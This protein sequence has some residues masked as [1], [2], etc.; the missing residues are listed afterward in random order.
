[1]IKEDNYCQLLCYPFDTQIHLDLLLV[2]LPL[3]P[4]PSHIPPAGPTMILQDHDRVV[5]IGWS[6]QL[7]GLYNIVVT[8]F[9]RYRVLALTA[10]TPFLILLAA[11]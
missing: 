7:D 11:K 6:I 4:L 8:Y 2:L 10:N 9:R 1:M 3:L 5:S